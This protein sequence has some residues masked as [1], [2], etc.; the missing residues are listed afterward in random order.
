MDALV[1]TGAADRERSGPIRSDEA[2]VDSYR[3]EE[4]QKFHGDRLSHGDSRLL[5]AVA[6]RPD[7]SENRYQQPIYGNNH[8]EAPGFNWIATSQTSPSVS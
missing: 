7:D 2:A 4:E 1:S 6:L 3:A 5:F 8:H